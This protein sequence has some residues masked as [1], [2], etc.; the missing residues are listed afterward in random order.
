MTK[1][2][3]LGAVAP[4]A[5]FIA[6]PAFAQ[7][8]QPQATPAEAA[9][10]DG[11]PVVG[12][13]TPGAQQTS[14]NADGSAAGD[15]VVVTGSRIRRPNLDSPVPVTSISGAEFFQTGTTSVGDVLNELPALTSTFSQSNSTRFLGT[16]GLSLLDL[17]GLG[18]Q[19]TLVLVNGRRH[20]AGDIL[21]NAVSPDVNTIPTDLIDRVD[22]VTGGS[23][24][25]Y[26]S[27]A[28]AGVVNF[29]LK[30]HYDGLQLRGQSGVSDEG[31]APSSFVSALAGKNFAGG[32]GNIALSLEYAHQ[33][34]FYAA[35]RPEYRTT[36][37]FV[38]V[39]NDPAGSING[40]DGNPDR[41]FYRDI[42]SAT[43]SNGGTFLGNSCGTFYCS[44]GFQPNG[45]LQQTTGTRVGTGLFGSFIGGNGDNFRDGTQLGLLPRQDRYSANL[46][47]HFEISRAFVPFIEAKYVHTDVLGS[48]S[49][50][51]FFNGAVTGS[52]REV[53]Y[54]DNP[55]LSTQARN[56]LNDYYG[57]GPG[58][59][60]PFFFNENATSLTNRQ[61]QLKRDTYRI[62]AGVRGD[63]GSG[64]SYEVSGNYG[65]F[66]EENKILGNVNLQRFL[67][68][69]DAVDQ[70]LVQN[71][72]A[73][74]NIVCRATVDPSARIALET[75]ANPA[76]AASQLAADVAACQPV[77]LFGVGNVSQAARNY[78]LQNSV[79]NGR[80]T[81]FVANA[82]ISGNS[83]KWF[84]LPGGPVGFSV[85]A[86]YRRET[87]SYR[88]DAS[89]LAGLTFYN[90][91]PD[92]APPA[93]EV[94]E[95]FGELS[96]PL[97]KDVPFF[98]D[99]TVSGAVRYADYKGATG[100]VLA[101]NGNLEWSPVRDLRFRGNYSRSVR[102]PTLVDLYSPYGQNF[103]SFSDP[104][105]ADNLGEGS[106]TRVA[107][108]R[109]DGVPAGFNFEYLNSLGFQSGGNPNLQAEK[110]DSYTLGLVVQPRWVRGLSLTV[111]WFDITVNN[112]IA[113][114]GAQDIVDNCYDAATLDN[115]YCA[116]F[117][118]YT[119]TGTGP[120]GEAPGQILENNLRAGPL[121]Y[122]RLKV[123]GIDAEL[124]YR[125]RIGSLGNLSA[126][127]IYTH[128]FRNDSYLN[129]SDPGRRDQS[130]GELGFPEDEAQLSTDFQ[131][132]IFT[133]GYKMRYIGRMTYAPWE[134]TH[135]VQG[136]PPEDA[137]YSNI[138]YYPE[139]FYH[140]VRAQIDVST[141]YNFYVGVDNIID[142][143][144]PLGT[145]GAG[146]GSAIYDNV[147]RRFYAGVVAKF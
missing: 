72:V 74:G 86:E 70:G 119:G 124:G 78:L 13:P 39:D 95:V 91:I 138:R 44:Y 3:L 12:P 105:A 136:R 57:V 47:G 92:F 117:E 9:N 18:P 66:D 89:T 141:K 87:A 28:I 106:A 34:D 69:I 24:A 104:C 116:L 142:T 61:E 54:T 111:D 102:A 135:S 98:H 46:I 113:S 96:V 79:A 37:G 90:S 115:Q 26:G 101:Y 25:V 134:A 77:N 118:R 62:V 137:D 8:A 132:G 51:F 107:N 30:D 139:T 140:D 94:K 10:P 93:F 71:G 146:F 129:P 14:G 84:E 48:A 125:S 29:V 16:S 67:L 143:K 41:V 81:Q 130:L 55:Y 5:L 56:F 73:N 59:Q 103:A 7:D 33:G 38:T 109:A 1:G 22:V 128:N 83:S 133:L 40:S 50:P 121:N 43:Y 145:T 4:L 100:N 45:T 6:A 20:V 131:T 120:R 123:R 127:A 21:N 11:K 27:D 32:R 31:D 112:S 19:R 42:R 144:P 80:I 68:A 58:T 76:F 147:G 97:L 23:S 114:V 88:E 53:F 17:R 52:P 63:F 126:R 49:G 15:D 122:A 75:A 108:C 110:S 99:L 65:R 2:H 64:W 60:Q 85:G 35:D 82:F 36:N